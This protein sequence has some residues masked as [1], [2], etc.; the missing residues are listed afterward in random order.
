MKKMRQKA[1]SIFAMFLAV[2]FVTLSCQCVYASSIPV[3]VPEHAA[4]EMA[5]HCHNPEAESSEKSTSENPDCCGKCQT[6][7]AAILKSSFSPDKNLDL[8]TFSIVS[9]LG[10]S[11]IY[12]PQLK[13]ASLQFFDPPFLE[14]YFTSALSL[15]GPPV[16]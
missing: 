8:L 16:V 10:E 14:S 13:D 7:A 6:E 11:T 12:S 4:G 3:D 15:R 5:M 2:F 9:F 1:T